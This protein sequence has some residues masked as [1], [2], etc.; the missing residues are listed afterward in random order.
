MTAEPPAG[1]APARDL[2]LDA[3][4]HTDQ[5]PDSSVPI[6]VYAALA[7][8]SDPPAFAADLPF[9]FDLHTFRAAG[10]ATELLLSA[11][12]PGA[13]LR[14]TADAAGRRMRAVTLALA[15]VD[16]QTSTVPR[17]ETFANARGRAVDPRA[18][19]VATWTA[20]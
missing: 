11:A 14:E 16:T 7:S 1:Q 3:H 10:G 2:P 12:V 9:A 18:I 13:A 8:D 6:D 17:A 4:L 5:S 20:G 19:S 15:V